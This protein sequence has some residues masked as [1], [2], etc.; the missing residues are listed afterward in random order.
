MKKFHSITAQN[1]QTDPTHE[2]IPD[3]PNEGIAM[4]QLA[5]TP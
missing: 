3:D 1:V 5:G 2:K 4:K